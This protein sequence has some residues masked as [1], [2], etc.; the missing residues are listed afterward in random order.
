[1]SERYLWCHIR[2]KD[3]NS[4]V[5]LDVLGV[6]GSIFFKLLDAFPQRP[7]KVFSEE[8]EL[9][10]QIGVEA[11]ELFINLV[12]SEKRVEVVQVMHSWNYVDLSKIIRRFTLVFF[13]SVG[14][15]R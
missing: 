11:F 7:N 15:G 13:F 6:P 5:D 1:M 14:G 2:K 10:I 12:W 4:M 9:N 3:P 8:P